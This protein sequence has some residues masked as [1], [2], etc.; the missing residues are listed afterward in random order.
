MSAKTEWTWNAT[1]QK[2][3]DKAKL[4]VKD[5]CMKFH[6]ETKPLFIETDA[7]GV[8]LEAAFLQTRSNTSCHRGRVPDNSILRPIA[9]SN[10]SLTGAEK[11]YSNIKREV[12]DILYGLEKFYHYYFVREVSII[13][14]HKLLVAIIKK[15]KKM[16]LHYQR[17]YSESY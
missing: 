7:S 1:Y 5:V 16:Y 10:K 11:R 9:F 12:L 6:N 15:Q 2:I 3:F 4:I 13:T 17:G 14:D 8:G